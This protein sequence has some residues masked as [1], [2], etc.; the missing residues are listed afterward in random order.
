M[1]VHNRDLLPF[2]PQLGRLLESLVVLVR[3]PITQV[4]SERLAE[5]GVGFGGVV[6]SRKSATNVFGSLRHTLPGRVL[7]ERRPLRSQNGSL[8]RE[9]S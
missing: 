5:A 4:R 6:A 7:S 3:R 2:V 9:A 8:L 1:N